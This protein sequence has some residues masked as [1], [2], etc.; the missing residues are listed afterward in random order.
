MKR[1]WKR[2]GPGT[3]VSR[4]PLMICW[5]WERGWNCL[6]CAFPCLVPG[7]TAR[8]P[9]E[10]GRQPPAAFSWQAGRQSPRPH[11]FGCFSSPCLACLWL[12]CPVLCNPMS[13]DLSCTP[14]PPS[15]PEPPLK[16]LFP[17]LQRG[18]CWVRLLL[19]SPGICVVLTP[20]SPK[21]CSGE[22]TTGLGLS[23]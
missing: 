6:L 13:Q 2:F 7:L 11:P 20:G 23:T 9:L 17:G 4:F 19:T 15:S 3:G 5:Q 21:R 14:D 1:A 10:M 8:G 22:R 18:P 16:G 12:I